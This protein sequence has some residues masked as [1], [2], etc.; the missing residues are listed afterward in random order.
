MP[1]QRS[2]NLTPVRSWQLGDLTPPSRAVAGALA[3]VFAAVLVT[4]TQ[5]QPA[6][7][8]FI[9]LSIAPS[10]LPGAPGGTVDFTGTI[11]NHTGVSL[12]AT[13]LG[14]NFSGY[15]SSVVTPNQVLGIPDFALPNTATSAVVDLFSVTIAPTAPPGTYP[16]DASLLDINNNTSNDV[17]VDVTVGQTAVP[18]PGTLW[19]VLVGMAAVGPVACTRASAPKGRSTVSGLTLRRDGQ[20]DGT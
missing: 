20:G 14:F 10:S 6:A 1:P 13:D 12:N 11:A 7:A 8:Q 5:I 2:N 3:A 16:L 18:E 19:L 15:D 17:I 4:C 9:D